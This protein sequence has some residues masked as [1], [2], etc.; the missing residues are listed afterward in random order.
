M[1]TKKTLKR[2]SPAAKA[3]P[4]S[5]EV[6]GPVT[7]SQAELERFLPAA[8]KLPESAIVPFRADATLAYHNAVVGVAALLAR[9][10]EARALPRTDVD[11]LKLLPNQCLAV[12]F[13]AEQVPGGG[14]T[15]EIAPK[16]ARAS[17]LRKKLLIGADAL[18]SAGIFPAK[19]VDELHAGSGKL[20][21]AR[22]CVGLGAL[23]RKHAGSLRG[24]TAV[25]AAEISEASALGDELLTLL[26]PT[27]AKKTRTEDVKKAADQRDRMWTLVNLGHDE[28]WKA[29]AYI[30]GEKEVAEK[31]P[32]LQA[33]VATTS[34]RKTA[35][36]AKKTKP[37]G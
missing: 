19:P 1:A 13:A 25:T 3:A 11:A 15:G 27:K 16:L 4:S 5:S 7:G 26:K 23:Y 14:T 20:D 31:V 24:K 2:K 28:L 35:N 37:T 17:V 6:M 32:A 9:E 33:R 30:Y 12:A 10:K 22:D 21:I 34:K 29:C 8:L 36:A 18:V